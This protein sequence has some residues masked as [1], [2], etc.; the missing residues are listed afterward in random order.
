MCR[1]V[2]PVRVITHPD[3][4]A[5]DEAF[6]L[7]DALWC[8]FHKDKH[9]DVDCSPAPYKYHRHGDC[10]IGFGHGDKSS[11]ERLQNEMIRAN[12][13]D[14]GA[15]KIKEW[16]LG[17]LHKQMLR[18]NQEGDVMYRRLPSLSGTDSWHASE[19][20]RSMKRAMGFVWSHEA[21]EAIIYYT[22]T[23]KEYAA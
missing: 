6:Y 8:Y 5:H 1:E 9:A 22:P 12:P 4:H 3:N 16:H 15:C 13:M 2:A 17:H 11:Y 20:Y 18:E 19:G 14:Y 23:A 10:L 21:L 7:G